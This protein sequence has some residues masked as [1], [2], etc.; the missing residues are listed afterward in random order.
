M[1]SANALILIS[2]FTYRLKQLVKNVRAEKFGNEMESQQYARDELDWAEVQRRRDEADKPSTLGMDLYARLVAREKIIATTPVAGV[3]DAD[4]QVYELDGPDMRG[5]GDEMDEE[6]EG[7]DDLEV[8][9]EEVE[10]EEGEEG[11]AMDI[12][13]NA[14]DGDR[15]APSHQLDDDAREEQEDAQRDLDEAL[16]DVASPQGTLTAIDPTIEQRIRQTEAANEQLDDITNPMPV[17]NTD[18]DDIVGQKLQFLRALIGAVEE[19]ADEGGLADLSTLKA[20]RK[21]VEDETTTQDQKSRLWKPSYEKTRHELQFHSPYGFS[22]RWWNCQ[23]VEKTWTCPFKLEEHHPRPDPDSDLDSPCTFT[24]SKSTDRNV[25]YKHVTYSHPCAFPAEIMRAFDPET[26]ATTRV[27]NE[28]M[29]TDILQREVFVPNEKQISY[30]DNIYNEAFL[31]PG[32]LRPADVGSDYMGR[33]GLGPSIYHHLYLDFK[34][35]KI[36]EG[37]LGTDGLLSEDIWKRS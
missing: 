17:V 29:Q 8:E 1:S 35:D 15:D 9:L 31:V 30:A 13:G 3:V 36:P 4:D 23:V 28:Q 16:D 34:V 18:L 14:T 10:A 25:S 27:E 19:D 12:D 22:N 7:E 24:V 20:C 11:N 32:S 2:R 21:C 5:E 33:V 6:G 37:V 26:R